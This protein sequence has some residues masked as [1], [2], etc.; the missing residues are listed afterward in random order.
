MEIMKKGSKEG[1]KWLVADLKNDKE[2]LKKLD[3]IYIKLY[4]ARKVIIDGFLIFT[5]TQK[6][7]EKKRVENMTSKNAL[8]NFILSDYFKKEDKKVRIRDI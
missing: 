1:R 8:I 2:L 3:N 7:K 5:R 6:K 4:E